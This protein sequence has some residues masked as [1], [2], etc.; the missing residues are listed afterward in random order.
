M[1]TEIERRLLRYMTLTKQLS[2]ILTSTKLT[3][4]QLQKRPKECCVVVLAVTRTEALVALHPLLEQ[5]EGEA[6]GAEVP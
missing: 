1:E 6:D 4:G 2:E 5:V 3:A